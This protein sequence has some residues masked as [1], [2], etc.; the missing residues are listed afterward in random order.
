MRPRREVLESGLRV[1]TVSVRDARTVTAIV[2]VAAGSKYETVRTNGISH[3]L[4]H[5]C[6]KGTERYPSALALSHAFDELGAENNA[7]TAEEYTGYYAKAAPRLL[8]A[9]LALVA[10]VYLNATLPA[11]DI[12]RERGVVTE[13]INLYSDQP[14]WHAEDLITDL[15]Y[16]DQPAGWEVLGTKENIRS[17]SRDDIVRYRKAHYVGSGTTVVVVGD[18]AP[19]SVTRKVRELFGGISREPQAP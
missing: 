13:E 12:E 17:L 14:T 3:F 18:V 9:I 11:P 16:G 2:F 10:D 8:E 7:F 19:A 5:L 15:L 1:I 6:F 4:E